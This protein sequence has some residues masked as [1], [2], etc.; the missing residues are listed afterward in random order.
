MK[1]ITAGCLAAFLFLGNLSAQ[2]VDFDV[3]DFDDLPFLTEADVSEE[4]QMTDAE[5]ETLVRSIIKA[6]MQAE[7]AKNEEQSD[8]IQ[9]EIN[10]KVE[11][12][13]KKYRSASD[14]YVSQLIRE[15]EQKNSDEIEEIRLNYTLQLAEEKDRLQKEYE[16]ELKK[17]KVEIRNEMNSKLKEQKALSDLERLLAMDEADSEAERNHPFEYAQY[18]TTNYNRK[19]NCTVNILNTSYQYRGTTYKSLTFKGNTGTLVKDDVNYYDAVITGPY[20]NKTIKPSMKD[21]NCLKFKFVGDG[22]KYQIKLKKG[23]VDYYYEFI[24]EAGIPKEID[25]HKTMFRIYN[26]NEDI[27]FNTIDKIIISYSPGDSTPANKDFE[28]TF[29]DM[30]F[31]NDSLVEEKALELKNNPFMF[32]ELY[33]PLIDDSVQGKVFVKE[34]KTLYDGKPYKTLNFFGNTGFPDK[35]ATPYYI[36]KIDREPSTSDAF[37]RSFTKDKTIKFKVFGDGQAYRIGV[38][39]VIN[40]KYQTFEYKFRTKKGKVSEVKINTSKLKA[41]NNTKIDWSKITD[42]SIAYE[43]NYDGQSVVKKDHNFSMQIFDLSIY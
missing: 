9:V 16:E 26:G 5:V 32:A 3:T 30:N 41:W 13:L 43:Y 29:F 15:M 31:T 20:F 4:N 34:G 28:V 24:S 11:E 35:K 1:R 8:A 12:E 22:Q 42:F 17:Q 39:G 38:S 10:Q 25:I 36:V 23:D 14:E 40:G 6:E 21:A 19:G 7:E 18:F 33:K 27:D 2:A 37:D